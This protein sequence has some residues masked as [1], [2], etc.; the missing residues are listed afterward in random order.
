MYSERILNNAHRGV[1]VETLVLAALGDGWRHVGLG[2]HP[3]D[4]QRGAGP[5]RVRIQVRQCA[6]L[7][8]REQVP[9]VLIGGYRCPSVM[10]PFVKIRAHSWL[11]AARL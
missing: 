6:A 9:S 3:W 8:H 2:G 1:V 5:D 11:Q 4:V 10:N 7:S